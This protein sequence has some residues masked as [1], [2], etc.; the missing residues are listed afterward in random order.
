MKSLDDLVRRLEAVSPHGWEDEYARTPVA[1]SHEQAYAIVTSGRP[2]ADWFAFRFDAGPPGVPLPAYKEALAAVLHGLNGT[3]RDAYRV[4]FAPIPLRDDAPPEMVLQV[5]VNCAACALKA[6]TT[7]F[8][9]WLAARAGVAA[10]AFGRADRAWF[11][12]D[13]LTIGGQRHPHLELLAIFEP[14]RGDAALERDPYVRAAV[15][16]IWP[17]LG[18]PL[19]PRLTLPPAPPEEG[20]HLANTLERLESIGAARVRGLVM[21]YVDAADKALLH[22]HTDLVQA[23]LLSAA[24]CARSRLKSSHR[25]GDVVEGRCGCIPT[26]FTVQL[27]T[28]L[29]AARGGSRRR[30]R[31]SRV[32]RG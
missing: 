28:G 31:R 15:G 14:L 22:E 29:R 11:L 20:G 17:Q 4:A 30:R 19:L 24:R 12:L 10:F 27:H 1:V 21:S 23:W 7:W 18:L 2:W 32:G 3:P 6:G 8:A 5:L 16:W 9:T 13:G 26:T 25:L